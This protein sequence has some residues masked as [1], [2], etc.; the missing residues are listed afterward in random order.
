M[1]VLIRKNC[2]GKSK[3]GKREAYTAGQVLDCSKQAAYDLNAAGCVSKYLDNDEAKEAQA[4]FDKEQKALAKEQADSKKAGSA[5]NDIGHAGKLRGL[6]WF[7]LSGQ[8]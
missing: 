2:F 6:G 7:W 8:V 1:K 5:D 4:A 3:E